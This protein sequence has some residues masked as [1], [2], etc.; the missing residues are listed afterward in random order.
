M[1][2]D[3]AT[4]EAIALEVGLSAGT[5]SAYI[6]QARLKY[7]NAGRKATDEVTL[8]AR[9]IEDGHLPG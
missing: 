3:G 8:R 5:V 2:A 1:L 4:V 6:E 9:L 7:R